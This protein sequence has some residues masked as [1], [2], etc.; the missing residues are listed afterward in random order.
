[1]HGEPSFYL[2]MPDGTVVPALPEKVGAGATAAAASAEDAL[3]LQ[4]EPLRI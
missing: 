1:M 4:L 3:I 2:T